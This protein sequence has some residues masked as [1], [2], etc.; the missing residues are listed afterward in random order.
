MGLVSVLLTSMVF[1][2]AYPRYQ[3]MEHLAQT[4]RSEE[5]GLGF[6]ERG[7][8]LLEAAARYD[9]RA[10]RTGHAEIDGALQRLTAYARQTPALPIAR[11]RA[12]M[13]ETAWRRSA[14]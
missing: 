6:V 13:L 3:Q 10:P 2:L 8:A 12:E 1:W 4:T 9:G 7:V 14:G 5:N 11:Q